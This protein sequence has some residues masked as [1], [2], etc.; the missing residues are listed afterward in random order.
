VRALGDARQQR[1]A[2]RAI[3]KVAKKEAADFQKAATSL[4][5]LLQN[6]YIQ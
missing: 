4:E 5:D 3:C 2:L 6:N 1:G